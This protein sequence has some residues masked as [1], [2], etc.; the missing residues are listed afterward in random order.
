MAN[1]PDS[2]PTVVYVCHRFAS[3]PQHHCEAVK[4]V[5]RALVSNGCVPL[6]P[7]LLLPQ[8]MDEDTERD[9]AIRFCLRLVAVCD[10]VRVFGE[11]SAGMRLE[12]AEAQRLGIP[13]VDERTGERLGPKGEPPR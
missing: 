9:L 7:Q 8:F 2:R 6:A 3:D 5:C 4:R 11:P 1:L 13:V 10:K 12:I